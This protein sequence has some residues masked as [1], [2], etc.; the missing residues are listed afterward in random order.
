MLSL[1]RN[2]LFFLIIFSMFSAGAIASVNTN[3]IARGEAGHA[4]EARMNHPG[5]FN[6]AGVA[7]PEAQAYDRG[8]EEGAALGGAAG[9]GVEEVVPIDQVP[10]PVAV[11]MNQ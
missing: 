5:E 2:K 10:E 8:A 7:H 1:L 3:Y 9:A 11:P 4:G 6:R